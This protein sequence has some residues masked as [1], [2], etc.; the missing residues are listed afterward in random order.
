M[1]KILRSVQSNIKT[2]TGYKFVVVDKHGHY[3]SPYTGLRYKKGNV[4]IVKIP[5]QHSLAYRGVIWDVLD[6]YYQFYNKDY[7]GLTGII[8]NKGEAIKELHHFEYI[9][10]NDK[11]ALLEMTLSGNLHM[12]KYC[13]MYTYVG[14]HIDSFKKIKD[15]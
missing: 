14:N 7:K 6:T 9:F 13:N 1:C 5:L 10:P 4:P 2:V 11:F 8:I 15:E 3:Y 12:G